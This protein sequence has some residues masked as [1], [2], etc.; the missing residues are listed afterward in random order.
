MPQFCILFYA[1]YT[2]LAMAQCPPLNTPLLVHISS[3]RDKNLPNVL[4]VIVR[5]AQVKKKSNLCP[6]FKLLNFG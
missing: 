1:K 6:V 4:L 5:L 3:V 2:I